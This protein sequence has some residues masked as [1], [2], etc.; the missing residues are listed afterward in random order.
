[1]LTKG[2]TVIG[3][4]G[5]DEKLDWCKNDLGFDH[6]FNYKKVNFSEAIS[7]VAP[8]GVD[9]FFDNVSSVC[10]FNAWFLS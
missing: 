4:V 1:M 8:S 9:V 7:Q 10:M 6:V 5:S 2:C 3:F